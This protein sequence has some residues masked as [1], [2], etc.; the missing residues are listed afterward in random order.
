MKV[1][2]YTLNKSVYIEVMMALASAASLQRTPAAIDLLAD[3]TRLMYGLLGDMHA[4]GATVDAQVLV[5]ALRVYLGVLSN[6]EARNSAAQQFDR[7]PLERI[8]V[9]SLALRFFRASCSDQN[10]WECKPDLRA[11]NMLLRIL[12]LANDVK[13]AKSVM[14]E[15]EGAGISPDVSSYNAILISLARKN[16]EAAEDFLLL[17]TNGGGRPNSA[18]V[19]ALLN[20]HM[21]AGRPEAAVSICQHMFNQ[22]GITPSKEKYVALFE[23]FEGKNNAELRRAEIVFRQLWPEEGN[24]GMLMK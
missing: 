20:G 1:E 24:S 13:N 14:K 18:T 7:M 22:W 15:M 4:S 2:G 17:L 19:E 8:G 11:Y 12:G 3:P 23:S 21:V 10:G 9:A 6:L 5:A 16:T